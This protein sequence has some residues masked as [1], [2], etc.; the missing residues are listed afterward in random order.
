M[1]TCITSRVFAPARPT[2]RTPKVIQPRNVRVKSFDIVE[3]SRIL[4]EA[5]TAGVIF[6][7]SLQYAH[8]RR[9]RLHVE[10]AKEKR[11]VKKAKAKEAEYDAH[12]AKKEKN[13]KDM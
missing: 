8:Y 12:W 5:V 11:D 10:D 1:A 3:S 9:I 6:Y 4:G 13:D 7:T 2:Y